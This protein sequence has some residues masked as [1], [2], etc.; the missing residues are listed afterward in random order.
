MVAEAAAIATPGLAEPASDPLAGAELYRDVERFSRFAEH[1]TG[2]VG[3]QAA[4]VWLANTMALAGFSIDRQEVP[5]PIF[6]P[7]LASLTVGQDVVQG[8][9]L[10]PP[11]CTGPQG[12]AG[13]LSITPEPG[14]VALLDFGALPDQRQT[15]RVTTP[16]H[17]APTRIR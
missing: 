16:R 4:T 6:V 14:R 8:F 9:P 2:G 17:G 5:V 15:R 3:E 11:T 7:E 13:C 1:R 10:W 12:L